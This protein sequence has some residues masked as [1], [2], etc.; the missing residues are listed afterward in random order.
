MPCSSTQDT[1]GLSGGIRLLG[2]RI[3]ETPMVLGWIGLVVLI[4]TAAFD[5]LCDDE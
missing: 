4:P 3:A 2:S 1:L 5:T